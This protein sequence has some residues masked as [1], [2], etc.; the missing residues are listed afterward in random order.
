[1]T[2]DG[3]DADASGTQHGNQRGAG[4]HQQRDDGGYQEVPQFQVNVEGDGEIVAYRDE[5]AV[6]GIDDGAGSQ[7]ETERRRCAY[8]IGNQRLDQQQQQQLAAVVPM[9]R[10][11]PSSRRRS[12]KETEIIANIATM[13]N[14]VTTTIANLI[15]EGLQ[16]VVKLLYLPPARNGQ[17]QPGGGDA[18]MQA[19]LYRGQVS[20][21][22][23]KQQ[24]PVG[25]LVSRSCRANGSGT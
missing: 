15:V 4:G 6:Q 11:D 8:Q 25:T 13:D 9:A 12:R 5:G 1:M 21:A 16:L 7:T 20:F 10:R 2:Q 3:G 24:Q 22:V 17:R 19:L 14:G 23:Q 18:P